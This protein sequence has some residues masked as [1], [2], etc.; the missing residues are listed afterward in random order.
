VQLGKIIGNTQEVLS[1]ITPDS[2]LI[3]TGILQLNNCTWITEQ[4]PASP[5][6][7]S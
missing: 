2:R 7:P 4:K 5:T 1:G 3:P 6:P